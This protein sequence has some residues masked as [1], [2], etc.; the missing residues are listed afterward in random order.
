MA[1]YPLTLVNR[2]A[3]ITGGSGGI[4]S[5]VGSHFLKSGA[6]ICILGRSPERLARVVKE[7]SSTYS[8]K[9]FAVRADVGNRESV[10]SG[11][12]QGAKFLGGIDVL[13]N[14][15]GVQPPIGEFISTDIDEWQQNI[16][17]NLIGCVYCCKYA[18]PFLLRAEEATIVN[19][20]GGGAVSSRANFSAYATAKAGIVRFTEV[21][22]DEL[23][24]TNVRVNAIAPGAIN[25]HMLE[26]IIAAG[27]KAGEEELK[28]ATQ[29]LAHGGASAAA[30]AE[31]VAYLASR[32][33]APLTGKVIS[34]VWDPWRA[35]DSE[36]V[37]EIM[38]GPKYNLR[39]T[40]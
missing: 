24:T 39:R 12:R 31:L 29:R 16:T 15:A 10:E 18:L 33:S 32:N 14:A 28:T 35:W 1:H 34:A 9:I 8:G 36:A 23:R 6:S 21:L 13:V 5:V 17:I 3:L 30:A 22:A 2:R 26:E 37:M 40:T 20:S 27:E 19:F 38:S 11:I 25:T 4:G 7:L